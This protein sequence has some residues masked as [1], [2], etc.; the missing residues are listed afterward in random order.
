M[1][2]RAPVVR[3]DVEE[4]FD[5]FGTVDD[6]N[7]LPARPDQ[8]ADS[9][10]INALRAW[11]TAISNALD[12]L[13]QLDDA[14]TEDATRYWSAPR[15]TAYLSQQ[16]TVL[17]DEI[18]ALTSILAADDADL[19]TAQERIDRIKQ[20]IADVETLDIAD[21]SEL[22][23]ELDE[24][25]KSHDPSRSYQAG[26]S[27]LGQNGLN[28]TAV[29]LDVWRALNNNPSGS[30]NYSDLPGL[31]TDAD[32][33]VNERY[34]AREWSLSSMQFLAGA[35][36]IQRLNSAIAL[37]SGA[38]GG[39]ILVSHSIDIPKEDRLNITGAHSYV[40]I[41]ARSRSVQIRLS[42][43]RSTE[44]VAGDERVRGIYITGGVDNRLEGFSIVGNGLAS[45]YVCEIGGT[46]NLLV[47][48]SVTSIDPVALLSER[49]ANYP[50][51][52]AQHKVNDGVLINIRS[53]SHACGAVNCIIADCYTGFQCTGQTTQPTMK[54]CTIGNYSARGTYLLCSPGFEPTDC[55]ILYNEWTAPAALA[56]TVSG[57]IK[58]PFAAQQIGLP[59]ASKHR[60]GVFIGNIHN[61]DRAP[62]I[63]DN[64]NDSPGENSNMPSDSVAD[65]FSFHAAEGWLIQ[66]PYARGGGEIGAVNVGGGSH[67]NLIV[68][69]RVEDGDTAAVAIGVVADDLNPDTRNRNN[70]V[71]GLACHR[72][73]TDMNHDHGPVAPITVASC[74]GIPLAGCCQL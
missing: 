52:T 45:S 63:Q 18:D 10:D 13:P 31:G 65:V 26:E 51:L 42:G 64:V 29:A 54:G 28:Y 36:D 40:R 1:A 34:N 38:G 72:S 16:I 71:M 11:L 3:Q 49:V 7:G 73:S 43:T 50:T 6:V 57:V 61:K 19:D 30:P 37:V 67:E 35:N 24:R 2:D 44:A 14:A 39:T 9:A 60:R 74:D 25:V 66:V 32:A 27:A 58:Q 22:R 68:G 4:K 17:Q 55:R 70:T 8:I 59:A 20:L 15:I 33:W 62:F 12:A 47:D 23:A 53:G 69:G 21:V 48:C 56:N 5:Y 46:R 41:K